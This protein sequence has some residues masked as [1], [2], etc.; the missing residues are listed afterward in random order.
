MNTENIFTMDEIIKIL[1]HLIGEIEPI[2]DSHIDEKR[3]C[4]LE[5]WCDVADYMLARIYKVAN[6]E[7]LKDYASANSI[8]LEAR[9]GL[10]YMVSDYFSDTYGGTDEM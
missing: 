5:L 7:S 2:A 6:D 1:E 4:N 9:R 10:A 3:L 8:I